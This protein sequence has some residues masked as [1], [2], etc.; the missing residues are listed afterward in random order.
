MN[1]IA[2]DHAPKAL[3]PYSQG[4][5]I[6]SHQQLIFVSGQLPIDP[7]S[8]KL[9]E[10]DIKRL[11]SQ[12][13][14]N[15]EAILNAAGSQLENVIRTDVF[16]IDLKEFANMNEI[17]AQ[18]FKGPVLP[19]RQTIQVAALPMGAPIEISCVAMI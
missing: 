3:G 11:T 18:R 13:I 2:T 4:V 16:L 1:K 6:S 19:A 7:G 10:G 5:I 12:V 15:I 9:V 14:D 8:G 17:Y